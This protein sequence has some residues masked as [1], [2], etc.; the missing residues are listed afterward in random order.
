MN[1]YPWD[2]FFTTMK[3]LISKW[4]I[5]NMN[6]SKTM[7]ITPTLMFWIRCEMTEDYCIWKCKWKFGWETPLTPTRHNNFSARGH[8]H[9]ISFPM[10]SR[11]GLGY[12]I[13]GSNQISSNW[14]ILVTLSGC[15]SERFVLLFVSDLG[16]VYLKSNFCFLFR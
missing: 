7:K 15:L 11:L 4:H 16:C 14:L 12:L 1:C 10:V 2:L 3:P 6:K 9:K 5:P 8:L 13:P